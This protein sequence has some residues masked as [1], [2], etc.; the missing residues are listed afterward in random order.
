[1]PGGKGKGGGGN[2]SFEMVTRKDRIRRPTGKGTPGRSAVRFDHQEILEYLTKPREAIWLD[3][4]G[5]SKW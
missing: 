4:A 1:L 2:E 5:G 3:F